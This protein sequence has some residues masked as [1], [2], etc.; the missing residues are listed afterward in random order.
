MFCFD[1]I[2]YVP[3]DAEMIINLQSRGKF[4]ITITDN[5]LGVLS[6]FALNLYRT[7]CSFTNKC[8]CFFGPG[9][10][11]SSNGGEI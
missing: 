3:Y 2:V 4:D 8:R 9:S 6:N 7:S 5:D 1:D 10:F 11:G